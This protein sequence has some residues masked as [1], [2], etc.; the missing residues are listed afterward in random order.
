[1]LEVYR[2]LNPL[3]PLTRTTSC[4][5]DETGVFRLTIDGVS[6]SANP[7]SHAVSIN[8]LI[9]EKPDEERPTPKRPD[10]KTDLSFPI[11]YWHTSGS[12]AA[13]TSLLA[14][15]GKLAS[16]VMRKPQSSP[17]FTKVVA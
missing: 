7:N 16:L 17:V 14:G 8:V 9:I 5:F 13:V 15:A 4:S 2:D 11:A 1:M 3:A 12:E 6:L 10:T